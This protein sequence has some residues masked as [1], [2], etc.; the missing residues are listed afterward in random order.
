VHVLAVDRLA[1]ATAAL[2][3]A[4]CSIERRVELPPGPAATFRSPTGLRF[5]IY[6]PTRPFVVESFRG[7]RDF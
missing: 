6:E 5:A 1:E 3:A 4:G 2:E 7:R